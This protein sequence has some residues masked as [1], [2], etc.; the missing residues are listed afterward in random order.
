MPRGSKPGEHRGGRKKGGVNKT[1]ADLRAVMQKHAEKVVPEL[2]RLATEAES[3]QVRCRAIETIFERAYGKAPQAIT[4]IDG[5][6]IQL[7]S[8][9]QRDA[10]VRA[11]NRADT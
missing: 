9:I 10:A 2:V 5:G 4:G 6:P 1:T 8:K 11:A 7:V 3:E